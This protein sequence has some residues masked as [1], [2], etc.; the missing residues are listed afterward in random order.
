MISLVGVL[1]T[2]LFWWSLEI[3]LL[4]ESLHVKEKRFTPALG[5]NFTG[6]RV[7][8]CSV[9]LTWHTLTRSL[10]FLITGLIWEL[11][12]MDSSVSLTS[13]K[14]VLSLMTWHDA[15]ESPIQVFFVNEKNVPLS[16]VHIIPVSKGCFTSSVNRTFLFAFLFIFTHQQTHHHI[17]FNSINGFFCF[18][19][20]FIM[21]ILLCQTVLPHMPLLT[22][23]VAYSFNFF[24]FIFTSFCFLIIFFFLIFIFR[25]SSIARFVAILS[26]FPAPLLLL[27]TICTK[28]FFFFIFFFFFT[29]YFFV[30]V[31]QLF[32]NQMSGQSIVPSHC[33]VFFK[34]AEDFVIFLGQII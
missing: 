25:A 26:T 34:P 23:M 30:P 32:A 20:F 24:I 28:C 11:P 29:F 6:H 9:P 14:P 17:I 5:K 12:W 16:M 1:T 19:K 31:I 2:M 3:L 13:F 18:F 21:A 33:K 8:I 27:L 4:C 7:W 15:P 10:P 22:A